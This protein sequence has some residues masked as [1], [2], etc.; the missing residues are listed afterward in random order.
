MVSLFFISLASKL[1]VFC[2]GWNV[3]RAQ[4]I[5]LVHQKRAFTSAI[6]LVQVIKLIAVN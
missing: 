1:F 2:D 4:P 5:L 6:L 3:S